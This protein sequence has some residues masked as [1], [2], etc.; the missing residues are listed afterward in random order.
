MWFQGADD[1]YRGPLFITKDDDNNSATTGSTRNHSDWTG[2][3]RARD[4]WSAR[5]RAATVSVGPSARSNAVPRGAT[6]AHNNFSNDGGDDY[7]YRYL[8]SEYQH[9][10]ESRRTLDA[11]DFTR[12]RAT[13]SANSASVFTRAAGIRAT[14]TSTTTTGTTT[15]SDL[16]AYFA[17]SSSAHADS[18][19][20]LRSSSSLTQSPSPQ[21]GT[22]P[23]LFS[24]SYSLKSPASASPTSKSISI[25][26]RSLEGAV[27]TP[28]ASPGLV[29]TTP[30]PNL[31]ASPEIDLTDCDPSHPD[32]TTGHGLDAAMSRARQ[33]SFVTVGP[34]PISMNT[35]NRDNL[36][37][38]RRESLA[39]SLMGG[40][41][42]G[43][44]SFGS[45]V[46]DE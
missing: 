24:R 8:S 22:P 26:T 40:L 14:G 36:N 15:A 37:R 4:A 34:K 18:P 10:E 39:G 19:A 13:S 2:G 32:M 29:I 43:G 17:S 23:D 27:K 9:D 21:P 25:L 28:S 1:D 38:N 3:A 44:M 46:R 35:Q 41:S 16:A 6:H 33:D 45:F 12:G 5:A 31:V 7:N 30:S 20:S 42:W 11:P